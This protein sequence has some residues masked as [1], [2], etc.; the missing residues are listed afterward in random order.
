MRRQ[1]NPTAGATREDLQGLDQPAES[2]PPPQPLASAPARGAHLSSLPPVPERRRRLTGTPHHY[3]NSTDSPVIPV[4]SARPLFSFAM[5]LR[6]QLAQRNYY[7]EDELRLFTECLTEVIASA[8]PAEQSHANE[9]TAGSGDYEGTGGLRPLTNTDSASG[10][11][12][13]MPGGAQSHTAEPVAPSPT[14]HHPSIASAPPP[15]PAETDVWY[16]PRNSPLTPATAPAL[17]YPPAQTAAIQRY[18]PFV[19]ADP[20]REQRARESVRESVRCPGRELVTYH[21]RE[22]LADHQAKLKA[23]ERQIEEASWQ[24]GP[25]GSRAEGERMWKLR[26]LEELAAMERHEEG[27]VRRS[28]MERATAH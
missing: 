18:Q 11:S 1:R 9:A 13:T 16:S 22:L 8:N 4:A 28:L 20:M 10:P 6:D 25:P 27:R 7:S 21:M 17:Q 23:I 19:Q 2:T 3:A 26:N 24:A 14:Y 12:H 5:D 15:H